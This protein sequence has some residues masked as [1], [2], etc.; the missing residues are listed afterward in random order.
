M[1]DSDV[2]MENY[3]WAVSTMVIVDLQMQSN[4]VRFTVAIL[5]LDLDAAGTI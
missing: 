1:L 5:G 4:P 3:V 2:H